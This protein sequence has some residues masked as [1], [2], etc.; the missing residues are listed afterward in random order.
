MGG[1]VSVR[2][3]CV[4]TGFYTRME[5]IMNSAK[6]IMKNQGMHQGK[7]KRKNSAHG[8]AGFLEKN[9]MLLIIG[10]LI[11]ALLVGVVCYINLRPRAILTVEGV[12]ANGNKITNTIYY[13][14]AMYDIYTAEQQYNSLSSLYEQFYGSTFWTAENVDGKGNNGSDSAKKEIMKALKKRE[15]LYMDAVKNGI[16]LTDDEKKKVE[17]D[18]KTFRDGLSDKQKDMFGLGEGTVRTVLE[19]QALADKYREQIIAGLNIDEAAEK[20]KVSKED[21]RQYDLQYYT[22]EKQVT[23]EE[24]ESKPKSEKELKKAK[25]D[26]EALQ[27]KAAKAKDFTKNIITDSDNNNEDDKTGISYNTEN[28]L[29]SDTDFASDDVLKK[30]K[31]MKNGAVSQVLEDDDAYYVVKMVNNNNQEAYENQC[32][33]AV[34][35]AKENGFNNKYKEIK[36]GYTAKTQSYWSKRVIIGYLTYDENAGSETGEDETEE[37]TASGSAASGS[38]AE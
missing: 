31:K 1:M 29:A 27:K 12:D 15:I 14:E 32:T 5:V 36:A 4:C 34:T 18:L 10:A 8:Q 13:K 11:M 22:I 37:D 30:I 38:S 3:V 28:L 26:I 33:Q 9:K 23:D 20:A 25:E 17:E 21:Y 19:K 6:K 7:G 24:G 16:S 2:E 35:D